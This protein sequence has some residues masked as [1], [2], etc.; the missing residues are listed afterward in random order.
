MKNILILTEGGGSLGYGHLTRC[1]AIAQA[2][3]E[4]AG[5]ILNT[6]S[7]TLISDP[8]IKCL[9]WVKCPSEIL[10]LNE[11]VW[12]NLILIDSYRA[13]N[14]SISFLRK[15]V[16]YL[17]VIDDFNR[18]Y[19]P[20]DLIINP[21]VMGADY[22]LKVES[23]IN[24]PDYVI[25]RKDILSCTPNNIHNELKNLLITFGGVDHSLLITSLFPMLSELN[26]KIYILTGDD[27]RAADLQSKSQDYNFI[28]LGYLNPYE[29]SSLFL[30]TDLAISAG[31]QTL[32]ELAFL[33]VPFIAVQT[34]SDQYWNIEGY[35]QARVTSRYFCSNDPFLP[36]L[37]RNAIDDMR[38][39]TPRLE[40]SMLSKSIIDGK[41]AERIA[42]LLI[43]R[44][45]IH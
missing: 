19:Y 43:D 38:N 6:C 25:L 32:N 16:N 12:P 8:Q 7:T 9:N 34:G 13:D 26:L 24:D 41:G 1:I 29:I 14:D 33:G 5:L 22:L 15:S 28:F 31:G 21:C 2:I 30:M 44:A 42:K 23:I 27:D 11:G 36:K 3:G 17:A 39:I 10:D 20:C 4:S 18:M 35:I 37:L 40:A 45:E